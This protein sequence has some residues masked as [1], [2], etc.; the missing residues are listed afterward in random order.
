MKKILNWIFNALDKIGKDK[1]QHFTFGALIATVAFLL[2]LTFCKADLAWWIS[3]FVVF[4][5][6]MCKEFIIDSKADEKDL[7]ATMLGWAAVG[8]PLFPLIFL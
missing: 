7:I 3:F 5:T 8:A 1:Y 2:L 4:L 6:E